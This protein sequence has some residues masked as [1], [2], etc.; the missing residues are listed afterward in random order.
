MSF[1]LKALKKLEEEKTARRSGP[2]DINSALLT[3]DRASS[4]R[5]SRKT[6]KLTAM[7]LV[8][9]AGCGITYL[10]LRH[11]P[12]SPTPAR[13]SLPGEAPRADQADRPLTN[14]PLPAAATPTP[15]GN[16]SAEQGDA[17]NNSAL[18]APGEKISAGEAPLPSRNSRV[19]QLPRTQHVSR[20]PSGSPPPGVKVNGIALQDDP[21]ASVAVV[22][23]IL[24]RRG[25]SVQDM[26]VEEIFSD[27]VRFSGNGQT[28]EVHISK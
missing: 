14:P 21:A 15:G 5:I 7:L 20:E 24:V 25:M 22:N 16:A 27:R 13:S 4:P 19:A 10:L 11:D 9:V 8:F 18:P 23:G 2:H 3:P 26:Q 28:W 17:G 6:L 1:I 12:A